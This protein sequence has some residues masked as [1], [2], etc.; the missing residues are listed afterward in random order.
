MAIGGRWLRHTSQSAARTVVTIEYRI[1]RPLALRVVSAVEHSAEHQHAAIGLSW[2]LASL[3][4]PGAIHHVA[5]ET[6]ARA[7]A[8]LARFDAVRGAQKFLVRS[9]VSTRYLPRRLHHDANDACDASLD[10]RRP[11]R[12][13]IDG[14]KHRWRH[15]R[16]WPTDYCVFHL[17]FMR[18]RLDERSIAYRGCE[19]PS[20][21][22]LRRGRLKRAAEMAGI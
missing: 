17:W 19:K 22:W 1:S 4:T 5:R 21:R 18:L 7:R 6:N 3:R 16:H 9:V 10:Y 15:L 2:P 11:A 12:A 8:R 20:P 14:D 13:R